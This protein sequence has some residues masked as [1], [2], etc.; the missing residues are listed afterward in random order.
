[1]YID[2]NSINEVIGS[3]LRISK[4][5]VIFCEQHT[6]KK[7]FYND[8]WVHNYN[9]L[10]KNIPGI[11]SIKFNSIPDD[12]WSQDWIKYGKIIVIEKI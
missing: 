6:D 7:S 2:N 3:I 12:I 5:M 4:K 8:K 9:Y 11:K 1:M 10:L